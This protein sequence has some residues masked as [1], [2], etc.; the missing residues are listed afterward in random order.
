[1][2]LVKPLFETILGASRTGV[3]MFDGAGK[4]LE[5][6]STPGLEKLANL[7]AQFLKTGGEGLDDLTAFLA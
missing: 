3:S 7:V 4:I 1:M 6:L 2:S 5:G